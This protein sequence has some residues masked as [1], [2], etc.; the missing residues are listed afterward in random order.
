MRKTGALLGTTFVLS[1]HA[2]FHNVICNW[3]NRAVQFL[4]IIVL[5]PFATVPRARIQHVRLHGRPISRVLSRIL[6][7]FE[8]AK[9]FCD[10]E[11]RHAIVPV[12]S[13]D[14]RKLESTAIRSWLSSISFSIA[15]RKFEGSEISRIN[16]W[17]LSRSM[18]A[19]NQMDRLLFFFSRKIPPFSLRRVMRVRGLLVRCDNRTMHLAY[20]RFGQHWGIKATLR[21]RL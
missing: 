9:R 6:W 18:L 15:V 3:R 4:S 13:H 11:D 17:K 8:Q 21:A 10:V 14:T 12:Y 16:R 19:G 7:I 20:S 1:L 2:V 5:L